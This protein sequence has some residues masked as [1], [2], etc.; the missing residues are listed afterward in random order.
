MPFGG[1]A[2]SLTKTGKTTT[3]T[4]SLLV[5]SAGKQVSTVVEMA[6]GHIG[7][8]APF[9][10]RMNSPAC[11]SSL[12]R[13]MKPALWL[14]LSLLAL[15]PSPVR[16]G[17]I[18]AQGGSVV[19]AAGAFEAG[20]KVVTV[21]ESMTLKVAEVP[22]LSVSN[23]PLKLSVDKPAGWAKGTRLKACNA[24]DVN[25]SGSLV[26]GSLEIR[27]KP[28]GDVLKEGEDYLVDAEWAGVGLGLRAAV[29]ARVV[30]RGA[31]QSA[32]WAR[33]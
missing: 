13:L 26:L 8:R 19:V 16:A 27:V 17:Q 28:N 32:C 15:S 18:T 21:K 12:G 23:E 30:G 22:V 6:L 7:S 3:S 5:R 24:R 25:A 14:S 11:T 29:L 33:W 4:F 31:A 10:K 2:Q 20:G 9:V 1:H